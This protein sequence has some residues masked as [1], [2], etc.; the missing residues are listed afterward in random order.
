VIPNQSLIQNHNST[1]GSRMT[2]TERRDD[3]EPDEGQQGDDRLEPR[4]AA[5]VIDVFVYVVVL[6][7]FVEYFPRVLSETFVLSL[8]TA[9]LLKVVLEVVLLAKDRVKR[10]FH[11]ASSPR[12]KV[13][14]AVMLW[15]VLIGSKFVV[16]EAVDLIFGD[17]VSLGG[18]LSVTL[19]ILALLVSRL[20]V[21]RLL[22]R[23]LGAAGHS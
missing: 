10:R 2:G 4:A 14:A 13:L 16:L 5:A 19:L 23:P 9:V 22:Q 20:A 3:P 6:N 21:R 7:L 15:V 8:L 17:R 1:N 18:F 12:G 11:Q